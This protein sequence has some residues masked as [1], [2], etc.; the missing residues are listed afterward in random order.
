LRL[1][2]DHSLW[3]HFEER[4]LGHDALTASAQGFVDADEAV[5]S[6]SIRDR[7]EHS[8]TRADSVARRMPRADAVEISSPRRSLGEDTV[9]HSAS[10]AQSIVVM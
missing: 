4:A 9:W 6:V 3:A 5:R 2:T 10:I 1:V 7:C 8:T